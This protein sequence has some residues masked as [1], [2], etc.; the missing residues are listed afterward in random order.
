MIRL[1]FR[2]DN[3]II[4]LENKSFNVLEICIKLI[5]DEMI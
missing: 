1:F 2:C 3:D 5:K 4:V